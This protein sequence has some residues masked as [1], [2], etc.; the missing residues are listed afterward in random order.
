MSKQGGNGHITVATSASGT[1]P[2]ALIEL[3]ARALGPKDIRV[4]VRAIGVNPVD[5]KMRSGGPLRF[6]HRFVG[7]SGQLVVGVDFAGEVVEQGAEADLPVGARVVGAT[8]FSRKQL[9]SYANEVVVRD[10]Q[11]A[12]LPNAVSFEDAACLPVPGATALRA[13]EL[14]G[15][16]TSGKAPD[17]RVLVLGAAGGVGLV[18]LQIA[19]VLGMKAAGVCSTRNTALVEK[20]GAASIDYTKGD[21]LEAAAAHGPYDLILNVVGSEIYSTSR[22]RTLLTDKG[23]VVLAVVRPADVPALLFS[24]RVK[25]VLGRPFRQNLEP[26][27][28]WLATRDLEPLIEATFPLAEAE[29]AHVLSKG[30][31][32]VGKL[33]LLP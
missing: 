27:V 16:P 24:S 11:C 5:W 33:L 10:D 30:G 4:R 9:G 28:G 12:T 14:A 22:A 31:K 3:P 29:K 13:L 6:A 21:A 1:E 18:T 8:D 32:V 17:V 15:L 25:H 7:P 23:S 26:L 19:R 20:L 2:L